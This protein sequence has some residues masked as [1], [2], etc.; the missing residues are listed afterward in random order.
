M[1]GWRKQQEDSHV[2]NVDIGDGCMV[3]GVFDGHGGASVAQFV[4]E[5]FVQE[6]IASDHFKNKEYKEALEWTFRRMDVLMLSDPGLKRLE[7]IYAVQ[8]KEA[9]L[10]FQ[11]MTK[12]QQQ[13]LLAQYNEAYGEEMEVAEEYDE[14]DEEFLPGGEYIGAGNHSENS[15]TTIAQKR[16]EIKKYI[17]ETLAQK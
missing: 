9:P 6:L 3:F 16:Q 5:K 12:E 14:E 2:V 10:D 13:K 17:N 4:Q 1:Q 7:E 8:P 15:N 11:N